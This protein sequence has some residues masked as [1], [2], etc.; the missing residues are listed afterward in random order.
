MEAEKCDSAKNTF[1][2][3]NVETYTTEEN[4]KEENEVEKHDSIHSEGAR[5]RKQACSTNKISSQTKDEDESG[6]DTLTGPESAAA[7]QQDS[8]RSPALLKRCGEKENIF[9]DLDHSDL[10]EGGKQIAETTAAAAADSCRAAA[11]DINETSRKSA[12]VISTS[13]NSCREVTAAPRKC[14]K[15]SS[16]E[17]MKR[18][19]I[20][21]LPGDTV[22]QLL[23]Y[24]YTD[25]SHNVESFSQ[26]LLAASERY[27]VG[28]CLILCF[29]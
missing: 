17:T 26:T 15:G 20:D 3:L 21:D 10:S 6:Q 19:V 24:I 14:I 9:V 22:E 11:L 8:H 29:R 7:G 13:S 27:K 18:L 16:P 4:S 1:E 2:D 25:N 23:K 5:S 28:L 12:A